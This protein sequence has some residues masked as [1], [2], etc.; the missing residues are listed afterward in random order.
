MPPLPRPPKSLQV[1]TTTYFTLHSPCVHFRSHSDMKEHRSTEQKQ[2]LLEQQEQF[3]QQLFPKANKPRKSEQQHLQQQ[4]LE[5]QR[6]PEKK[7][8]FDQQKIEERRRRFIDRTDRSENFLYKTKQSHP[9]IEYLPSEEESASLTPSFVL[10]VTWPRI[11]QF[12]HPSSP[13][14]QS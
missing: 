4:P 8:R 7:E 3:E 5:H 1:Q 12:Y 2:N 13:H 6:N 10:E 9:I 11:I 14:C